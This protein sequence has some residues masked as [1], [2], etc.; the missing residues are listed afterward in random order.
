MEGNTL[1]NISLDYDET[2]TR[3]PEFWDLVISAAHYQD[4]KVYC[5]TM[6]S[7]AECDDV[8]ASLMNKVDGIFCTNRQA[9]EKYMFKEGIMI[10]VWIDDMP[11]FILN[12]ARPQE[13][14]S[15]ALF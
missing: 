4:H 7:A 12:N 9:K 8:F 15:G 3:D 10:D 13:T 11:F 14:P 1:M 5:V 2:Y 6:R